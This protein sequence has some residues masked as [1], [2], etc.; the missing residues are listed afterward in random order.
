VVREK[1][2]GGMILKG[3][4]GLSFLCLAMAAYQAHRGHDL[5]TFFLLW[6][7]ALTMMTKKL[8]NYWSIHQHLNKE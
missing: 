2:V 8:L 1:S 4:Q 3:L 6:A 5:S 7:F